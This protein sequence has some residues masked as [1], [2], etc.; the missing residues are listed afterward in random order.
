VGHCSGVNEPVPLPDDW[1]RP[2]WEAARENRLVMQR[3]RACSRAQYPPDV[4]CRWCQNDTF[5]YTDVSG[6][7]TVYTFAVYTRS[8][9][10][11]FEAPY[12][13]ALIDLDDEPDV[14]MLT[15]I[16]EAAVEDVRVDLP[17][18]VVFEPRGE[19]TVPQFRPRVTA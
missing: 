1:S 13:L 2:Y 6:K 4:L 19:W 7:G 10:P 11:A 9:V 16:V 3:C 15:N 5:A 12:V 18:E 8:F 17:V 14:R